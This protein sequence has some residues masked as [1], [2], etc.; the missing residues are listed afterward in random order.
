[1]GNH[2]STLLCSPQRNLLSWEV[3]SLDGNLAAKMKPGL[4]VCKPALVPGL[5]VGAEQLAISR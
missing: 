4:F 3:F 5:S 1:M 2:L